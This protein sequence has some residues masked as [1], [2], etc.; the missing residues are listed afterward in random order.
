MSGSDTFRRI[1]G[2]ILPV[3]RNRSC[4]DRIPRRLR[5]AP[6]KITPHCRCL[7]WR[8]R[9]RI[10]ADVQRLAYL[11]EARVGGRPLLYGAR[12]YGVTAASR[13][14]RPTPCVIATHEHPPLS[15]N[16]LLERQPASGQWNPHLR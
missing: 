14:V 10:I 9:L 12:N 15:E 11:R 6:L 16:S 5:E 1:V 7:V 3:N 2:E 8:Y 4:R 13:S